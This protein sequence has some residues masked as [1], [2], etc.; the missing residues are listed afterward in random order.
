VIPPDDGHATINIGNEPLVV[1]DLIASACT[2]EYDYYR[3]MQGLAFYVV[4]AGDSFAVELNPR[5]PTPFL[6]EIGAGSRWPKYLP[7][8]APLIEL[9]RRDPY[10]FRFLTETREFVIED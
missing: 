6:P 1:C 10:A 8:G 2:N 4:Q 3:Q 7:T 9:F 5:Y